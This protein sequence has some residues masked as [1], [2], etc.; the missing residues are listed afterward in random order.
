VGPFR[1]TRRTAS[2]SQR[3]CRLSPSG[4]LAFLS[5]QE[6]NLCFTT[7]ARHDL[8]NEGNEDAIAEVKNSTDH[9]RPCAPPVRITVLAAPGPAGARQ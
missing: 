1:L 2:T 8:Q 5:L 9:S 3:I 7:V 6:Y 4:T